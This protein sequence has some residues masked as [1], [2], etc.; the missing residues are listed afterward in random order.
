MWQLNSGAEGHC[1]EKTHQGPGLLSAELPAETME[2]GAAVTRTELSERVTPAAL[3]RLDQSGR[4][5]QPGEKSR[6]GQGRSAETG[7]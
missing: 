7:R 1:C 6:A 4:A 2:F 3:W 5:V